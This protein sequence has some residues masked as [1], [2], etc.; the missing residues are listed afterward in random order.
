[1]SVKLIVISIKLHLDVNKE[2]NYYMKLL[3]IRIIYIMLN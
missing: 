3:Y 1:M 2:I